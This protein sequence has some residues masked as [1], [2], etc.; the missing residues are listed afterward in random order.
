MSNLQRREDIL[1]ILEGAEKPVSASALAGRFGVSRQIIVGDVALLRAGG[2]DIIST[3]RGYV[4]AT[5][6]KG[7]TKTIVC[8]H[9]AQDTAKELYAIVDCGCTV[10]DV[11][12]EHPVY[13]QITGMLQLSSRLEVEDFLS[14]LN[15]PGTA[16]LSSLTEGVHIHTIICPNLSAYEV[17]FAKLKEMNVL[18]NP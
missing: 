11:I 6:H 18:L 15:E 17:L 7:L 5:G 12:V 1:Q 10:V 14:R 2:Y 3:A 9:N 4:F 8:C 13:G 16:P